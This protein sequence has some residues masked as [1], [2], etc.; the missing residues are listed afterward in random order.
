MAPTKIVAEQLFDASFGDC[1]NHQVME[2]IVQ[3]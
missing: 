1:Q 3:I 2:L